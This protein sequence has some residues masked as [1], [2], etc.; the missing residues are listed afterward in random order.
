MLLDVQYIA[1]SQF[2]K[3]ALNELILF[4]DLFSAVSSSRIL[5]SSSGHEIISPGTIPVAVSLH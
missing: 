2:V 5:V 1:P 4:M 3:I